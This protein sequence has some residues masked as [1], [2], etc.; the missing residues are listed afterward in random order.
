MFKALKVLG[1]E[2][3]YSRERRQQSTCLS[4][5]RHAETQEDEGLSQVAIPSGAGGLC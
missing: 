2:A 5:G 1:E 3:R 4:P